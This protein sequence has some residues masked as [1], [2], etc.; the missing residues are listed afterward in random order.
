LRREQHWG[1]RVGAPNGARSSHY[2]KKKVRE[3]GTET[4]QLTRCWWQNVGGRDA[5]INEHLA[6]KKKSGKVSSGSKG[7]KPSKKGKKKNLK[8]KR[9]DTR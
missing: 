2:R 6:E 8:K 4:K 1:P 5:P 3:S 7:R 9:R